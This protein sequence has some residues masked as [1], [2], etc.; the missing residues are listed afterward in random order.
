MSS[1][2]PLFGNIPLLYQEDELHGSP[3]DCQGFERTSGTQFGPKRRISNTCVEGRCIQ[4]EAS[5][6]DV[7]LACRLAMLVFLT[8]E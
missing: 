7:L 2:R 4:R 8:A 5:S 3:V 6:S 1:V